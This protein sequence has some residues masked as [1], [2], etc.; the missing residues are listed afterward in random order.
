MLNCLGST[1][2]RNIKIIKE[3]KNDSKLPIQHII[4]IKVIFLLKKI[5][6]FVVLQISPLYRPGPI[7]AVPI[8]TPLT[9]GRFGDPDLGDLA[10]PAY[11]LAGSAGFLL[12]ILLSNFLI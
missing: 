8:N 5:V 2:I 11:P 4:C 12:K 6:K 10:P 3:S 1:T 7:G 9:M